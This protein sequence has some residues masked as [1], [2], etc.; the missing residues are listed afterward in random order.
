MLP[1]AV[2][3]DNAKGSQIEIVELGKFDGAMAVGEV[4]SGWRLQPHRGQPR[5]T[6]ERAGNRSYL[7]LSSSGDTAYGIKKDAQI[8]LARFPFLNWT[9]KAVHLP[10]EGDIRKR[11]TDDQALQIYLAFPADGFA[12]LMTSSAIAY[13][14]DN[15]APKGLMV[16]S[17]QPLLKNV[18][19]VVMRNGRDRIG[20][21]HVE[22][23]NVY[24]DYQ[25]LIAASG[26]TRVPAKVEGILLFI[27]THKTKGE[28][29]GCIGDIFFSSE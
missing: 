19:Y 4:P 15:L 14:W 10:R 29:E 28:A 2:L 24:E 11:E 17:P 26:H 8:D 1:C 5:L 9:W 13:I 12:G 6:I 16:K 3:A 22:K 25:A 18:Q 21:W 27:N 23:R 20:Q 7:R